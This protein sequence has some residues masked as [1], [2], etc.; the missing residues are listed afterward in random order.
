MRTTYNPGKIKPIIQVVARILENDLSLHEDHDRLMATV[1]IN[2]PELKDKARCA[3]CDASMAQYEYNMD[4]LDVALVVAMGESVCQGIEEGQEFTEA[5]KI[6]IPTL[7]VSDA[8]RHR[9]TKCAKLGLIAKNNIDGKDTRGIWVITRRGFEALKGEE[10]PASTIVWRGKIID[11]PEMQ[12][13]FETVRR[14][15]IIRIQDYEK[16][17]RDTPR[18]DHRDAMG[19]YDKNDWVEVAGYQE[20]KL[21]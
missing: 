11:R 18:D 10:I 16:R 15:Y 19:A 8:V 20:G 12:T 3:N 2:V 5:N 4:V 6:H 7:Q 13:T 21:F 17:H 9:T 1:F 14:K